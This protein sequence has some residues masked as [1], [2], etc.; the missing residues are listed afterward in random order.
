MFAFMRCEQNR[1]VGRQQA[2]FAMAD[3]YGEAGVEHLLVQALEIMFLVGLG[4]VHGAVL[5]RW[6]H[7][8]QAIG[9]R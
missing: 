8:R 6:H 7:P 5:V 4:V 2:L 3:Q 9:T 1:Q